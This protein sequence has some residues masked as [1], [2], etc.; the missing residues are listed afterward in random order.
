M[1][2]A[3]E[4]DWD[5]YNAVLLLTLGAL[6][7]RRRLHALIDAARPMPGPDDEPVLSAVLGLIAT[8]D[9]VA[10]YAET[11]PAP[12][13]PAPTPDPSPLADLLR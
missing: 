11:T 3:R 1:L 10:A 9:R 7:A 13:P 2:D 12:A 6:G 5:R 8:L 4:A